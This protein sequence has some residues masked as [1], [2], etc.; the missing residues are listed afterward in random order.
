MP[1]QPASCPARVATAPRMRFVWVCGVLVP[2]SVVKCRG[3]GRSGLMDPFAD[4][5][6]VHQVGLCVESLRRRFG[7][8]LW[9]FAALRERATVCRF[10]GEEQS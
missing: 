2:K 7:N 3:L 8:S 9:A 10:R 5:H 1:K 4:A 6:S